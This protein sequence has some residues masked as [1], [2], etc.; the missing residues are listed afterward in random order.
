MH[1]EEMRTEDLKDLYEYGCWADDRLFPVV[2]QLTPQQFTQPVGG[3]YSSVRDVLVH[4]ASAQW[5]WL[6][7]CGGP[8]RGP[9]LSPPDFPTAA[10]VRDVSSRIRGYMSEFLSTLEGA[11][12]D[13]IIDCRNRN[14]EIHPMA[15]GELARHS[16]IHGV[17]HRG[18]IALMLQL[19][20]YDPGNFDILLYYAERRGI[21]AW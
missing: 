9:A 13:R 17:H 10:S 20:G 6:S 4:L 19:L 7:Q 21:S 2:L 11:D 12:L 8:Q 14:G 3:M 15:L 5:G 18:Q 1:T 16:I